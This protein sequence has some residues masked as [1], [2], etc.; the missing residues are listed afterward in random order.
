MSRDFLSSGWGRCNEY[1]VLEIVREY[2]DKGAPVKTKKALVDIVTERCGYKSSK[3]VYRI[4]RKAEELGLIIYVPG[5]GYFP[6]PS[7]HVEDIV[8][9][10]R[11]MIALGEL[12]EGT[13]SLTHLTR[14]FS[15]K[16][17]F[18]EV[19]TFTELYDLIKWAVEHMITEYEDL[20]K[21]GEVIIREEKLSREISDYLMKKSN[22]IYESIKNTLREKGLSKGFDMEKL[23]ELEGYAKHKIRSVI[24]TKTHCE[25]IRGYGEFE[26]ILNEVVCSSISNA[27]LEEIRRRKEEIDRELED[28]RS[29]LQVLEKSF[30]KSIAE[31]LKNIRYS[32]QQ[33]KG[34]CERCGFHALSKEDILLAEKITEYMIRSIEIKIS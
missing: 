6:R 21:L 20:K 18:G 3:H 2:C 7:K 11:V 5:R 34:V 25:E 4:V 12:K 33:L 19:L 28:L 32:G 14:E 27:L 8:K 31:E 17:F 9:T 15:T 23:K 10:F 1:D 24:I 26:D 30:I 29:R 16:E 13:I 22:D